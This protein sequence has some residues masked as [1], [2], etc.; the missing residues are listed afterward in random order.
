[1]FELGEPDALYL[2]D[3]RGNFRAVSWTDGTFV[4]EE[5]KSLKEAPWDQGLAV[6]FRDVNGDRAP[7]IYVCNDAFTPDR[8]WIN[9]G[10]GKFKAMSRLKW[11]S[12]SHSSMG[13]DF[14]D[15]D[16]DGDDDFI[17]VDML[18]RER[19]YLVTQ[20]GTIP[21]Q[22]KVPG[23]LLTQI[24]MRR[25]TFYENRGDGSY[26]EVANLLGVAAS[27]WSWNP[28]FIDLDLD[29][30]EDLLISN[31][32]PFNM[33]D[34]DT[35][36]RVRALGRLSVEQSRRTLMMYP[37]LDT[38]NIAF[39]NLRGTRFEV[40]S[41]EWGFNSTEVSNGMAM[42][43][44]DND[45]DC[46]LVV[47]TFNG[48]ALVYRNESS[49]PRLL[50]RLKGK[51]P[52]TQGIGAKIVVRGGPT[53][54]MQEVISGGRYAAGDD[55][56]RMFATGDAKELS[57]EVTWRNGTKSTL[58]GVVPNR[59]YEIEENGASPFT[60]ANAHLSRSM[61]TDASELL[62]HTHHEIEFND[63][64]LQPGLGQK[65]SRPGPGTT[66]FDINGDGWEDLLMG[67]GR[68][69]KL[70]IFLNH[71]GQ[72]REISSGVNAPDDLTSIVARRKTPNSAEVIVASSNFETG[73]SNQIILLEVRGTNFSQ[74]GVLPVE[75]AIGSLALTDGGGEFLLF[76]GG[77]F[78]PRR[79]PT[80]APSHLFVHRSGEWMEDSKARELLSQVGAV[81]GAAWAD[82]N[83]DAS[84]ELLVSCDW[85]PIRIFEYKDGAL[86]D[87]TQEWGMGAWF[88][89]WQSIATGDFDGDGRIDFAA[90]NWG[91]NSLY[92]QAADGQVEVYFG[93]FTEPGRVDMIEAYQTSSGKV[94]PWRDIVAFEDSLPW[95]PATFSTH[96]A[97]SE[98]S[99]N[100]ILGSK[101]A[102]ATSIRTKT[103]AST[104]FL[105]RG[106]HFEAVPLPRE[107]QFAPVFGIA[108]ADFDLDGIQDL[109]LAQNFFGTR[110]TD[111]PL[112]AGRG[113]LLRGR[114]GGHFESMAGTASG[115]IAY[116]EQRG[117]AVADFNHDGR[118]DL[119]V[120]Q[121]GSETKLFVN[122]NNEK[123]VRLR[124][125]GSEK[126]P[127]AIG[128][129]IRL[130]GKVAI[131]QQAGAGYLSQDSH[132][133]IIPRN[134]QSVEVSWPDGKKQT[135][136]IPAGTD[137]V[138]L[139][140]DGTIGR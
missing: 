140:R 61:F 43:D 78:I 48:P 12:T 33:D 3:G 30:W 67:S 81:S 45:G 59:I 28:L 82:L 5:G 88:G 9:D 107:V 37:K 73:R 46:D 50:V 11:R 36:D 133:K 41:D 40:V 108:V 22:P 7:D 115:F 90:G 103:L 95:L 13:V 55:P 83:D 68:G 4:D 124:L 76:A 134:T 77:K 70:Q 17:V 126:N 85:G 72:F 20:R 131:C 14:A 29:G 60:P 69:G 42:A 32:F 23:D 138:E 38:P 139:R 106:N 15:Y 91:T 71:E 49:A 105:N 117:C 16:R 110:E 66:W 80:A 123:G 65:L 84:P 114:S 34:M 57:V 125:A 137:S 1:M 122:S 129:V 18:S 75:A 31:G 96:L 104:V 116:G 10:T 52:N 87:R 128:A 19:K 35:K 63:F 136:Q 6:M 21:P 24:Q 100:Q 119:V 135:F 102:K 47:N 44:L 120:G 27:E 118:A 79:Y 97:Y 2:N 51:A 109:A 93:E 39:R 101:A 58:A 92:N 132:V 98:A 130:N 94:A 74:T 89:R 127:A 26:A 56:V 25:N 64:E 53:V 113:L 112:D 62:K 8:F 121:S 86:S 99:V 111:G 54:Q